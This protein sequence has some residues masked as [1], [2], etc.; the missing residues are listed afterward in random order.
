MASISVRAVAGTSRFPVPFPLAAPAD[1]RVT[2]NGVS[3][4][5]FTIQS[6]RVVLDTALAEEAT[7]AV[8]DVRSERPT[9]AKTSTAGAVAE[10]SP[11]NPNR[12]YAKV[13]NDGATLKRFAVGNDASAT[14]GIP[15]QP[16]TGYEWPIPPRGRI[17]VYCT[18]AESYQYEGD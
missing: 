15:L 5:A 2:V 16:N 14:L 18:A 8:T 7:V 6:N 13:F 1:C 9:V 17:T 4:L 12:R 10:V 11:A 3:T